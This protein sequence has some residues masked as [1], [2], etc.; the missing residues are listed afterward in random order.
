M[1]RDGSTDY[2]LVLKG[3]ALER[4]AVRVGRASSDSVE[5]LSGVQPGEQVVT[6]S[7][8]PLVEGQRVRVN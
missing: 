7:P 5:L 6:A 3:D 2:V 4:R 8:E 1:R